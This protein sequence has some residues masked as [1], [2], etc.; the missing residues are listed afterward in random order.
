MGCATSTPKDKY[1]AEGDGGGQGRASARPRDFPTF[2][3]EGVFEVLSLLGRGGEGETWL[4]QE[5]GNGRK[6]AIKLIKRPIPKPAIQIIKRE[7]KIQADLGEGNLNI[8]NAEELILTPSHLGLVME[9]VAGGN[10]VQF[11][12]KKRETK[13]LRGGLC[14]DE[15]EAR[16]YFVQLL[17]AVEYCH[18]HQVAHRDLKLDN[19]LLD[20]SDPPRIK[21]CD[22]GFAKAWTKSSNMD[23]MRI[24]TPEY[25]GPELISSRTGYDGKKVD[26]WAL[27]VLLFVMLL[28]Q[29][30]FE[31]MEDSEAT[32]Q[33]TVGLHDIWMQQIRTSWRDNPRTHKVVQGRLDPLLHDLLDRMF[34]VR[35]DKR[36]SV[37]E[38]KGHP[39]VTKPLAPKYAAALQ[40]LAAEQA[41][42][43]GRAASGQ[44]RSKDRDAALDVL[45]E[46]AASRSDMEASVAGK[47]QPIR[48]S[49][50]RF[51][52][53]E[54]LLLRSGT[55]AGG[56][57]GGG[58][59]STLAEE[60]ESE[61]AP[62]R[63]ASGMVGA[64]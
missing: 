45:L 48:I 36:I 61:A 47:A 12:T 6:R 10:M 28:G 9:Y 40:R 30:P 1:E 20:D 31:S 29:F 63:A 15:D 51:T 3:M 49:L 5:L 19:T 32:G 64:T 39:W 41:D 53:P 8:V 57:G 55:G 2:H 56:G 43:D 62:S 13:A 60:G 59:M 33:E 52:P 17:A 46:K 16:F 27:G 7:I 42:V 37:D 25:M 34:E 26:V 23:T 50:S 11:V 58:S 18:G 14:M 38:I 35:Q 22:F 4:C 21:L 24:G 44:A 54:G